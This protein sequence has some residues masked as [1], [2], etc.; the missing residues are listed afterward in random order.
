MTF[1]FSIAYGNKV[2]LER[3]NP[4]LRKHIG[5]EI[6]SKVEAEINTNIGSKQNE[7]NNLVGKAGE[8]EKFRQ[9][10]Q[11]KDPDSFANHGLNELDKE[12]NEVLKSL[13]AHPNIEKIEED[14]PIFT[15]YDKVS[16]DPTKYVSKKCKQVIGETG[17]PSWKE[18]KVKKTII[19]TKY[20]KNI[21]EHL[22]NQYHCRSTLKLKCT[23]PYYTSSQGF[24]IQ[25]IFGGISSNYTNGIWTLGWSDTMILYGGKGAIYDYNIDFS[26]ED[27]QSIDNFLLES[28]IYD[29]LVLV[30][31]NNNNVYS[32]PFGGDRLILQKRWFFSRYHDVFTGSTVATIE[33]GRLHAHNSSIDLKPLLKS[34]NNTLSI[35]LAVGG[36]GGLL[37]KIRAE[38]KACEEKDWVQSWEETCSHIAVP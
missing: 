37:M 19:N 22:Q 6:Q 36:R 29:D 4:S 11:E 1:I 9:S 17:G 15:V 28:I 2:E 24:K 3:L 14:D 13:L 10:M 25:S 32:G 27:L 18:L 16:K 7:V 20:E 31:L 26:L 34:G 23:K 12:H 8:A 30:K 21:C 35:R 33:Q 5:S 38:T